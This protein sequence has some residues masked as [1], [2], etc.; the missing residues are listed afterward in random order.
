MS[1]KLFY[2]TPDSGNSQRTIHLLQDGPTFTDPLSHDIPL[3]QE[4]L[5]RFF[6]STEKRVAEILL[7]LA[8]LR[9]AL[10]T[11]RDDSEDQPTNAWRDQWDNSLS[12]G[13]FHD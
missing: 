11:G 13:L 12:R 6:D 10:P 4:R 5:D 1:S 7:L 8:E 2:D 3:E 9:E